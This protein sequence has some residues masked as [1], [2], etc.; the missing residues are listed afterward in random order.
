MGKLK[1]NPH[2]RD[3]V[4]QRP[5]VVFGNLASASLASYLIEQDTPY[6]VVGFTVDKAYIEQSVYDGKP[7]VPFEELEHHFLPGEV[8]LLIP[9]GYQKINAARRDKF[10][11]ARHR[12]YEFISYISSRASTWPNVQLGSNCLIYEHAILQP[13]SVIGDNCIIR[14]GAHV[15]HHCEIR[16]H[17]F[18]AAEVAMGGKVKVGEQ[19]F[20]GVGSVI[21]DSIELAARTFVG[22]G[23]VITRATLPDTVYVG[24]PGKPL[25]KTASEV[26]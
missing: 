14:S 15:S 20:L 24:N 1:V 12:G 16:D 9:M 3:E 21:I 22:A 23:A 6:K 25:E 17:V 8:R 2:Y 19:S 11:S 26:C 5:I 13:F 4:D 7:L 10:T 18:I